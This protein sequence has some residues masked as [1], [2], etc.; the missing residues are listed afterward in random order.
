MKLTRNQEVDRKVNPCEVF[1][2][3]LDRVFDEMSR[4]V[5]KT[6]NEKT[7]RTTRKS[8][9]AARSACPLASTT[10]PAREENTLPASVSVRRPIPRWIL[11]LAALTC[12]VSVAA[13]IISLLTSV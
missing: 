2:S 9:S 5:E 10:S 13:L 6:Y 4:R 7:A 1:P 3:E 12:L 8:R 11:I